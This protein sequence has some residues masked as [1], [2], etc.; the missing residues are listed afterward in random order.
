MVLNIFEFLVNLLTLLRLR[1]ANIESC[2]N[3]QKGF[4]DKLY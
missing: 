2:S 3:N 4:C 1:V